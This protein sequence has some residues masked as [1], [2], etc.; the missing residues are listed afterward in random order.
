MGFSWRKKG[1]ESVYIHKEN[2]KVLV[3]GN[4]F[5]DS[6]LLD[7][8]IVFAVKAHA[9]TE[10][11]GKG[12]PYIVHPMEAVEIVAT[13][14]SDQELLAAAALHDTVEDT[15]VT[16]EDIRKEFGE[17]VAKIVEEESDKFMEGV[18][19]A[20]SWHG[21]KQAA[22][23]RLTAASRD[24]K[25]VALGDKLSNA[26]AIYRDYVQQGD[27]LWKIF[28]VTDK[29]EHEWHYRGLARALSDLAGTFAFVEF[30][31]LVQKVFGDPK[32]ECVNLRDYEVSGE[33]FTAVS[34][35]HK[36][37]S[38][39]I[40]L[41]ASFVPRTEA[42]RELE[43][44]RN[45]NDKGVVI[46]KAYRLVTDGERI[47]VEFE[48]IHPK[49]SFARAISYEPEKLEFYAREFAREAKKL[50]STPCDVSLFRPTEL[51]LKEA[52]LK[53]KD[54]DDSMKTK[55]L[56]FVDSVPL[57]KTCIHGD[58]HIGNIITNGEKN[59]WIDLSAFAYGNPLFDVGMLYF[60]CKL[61]SDEN[62][63]KNY[64]ISKTQMGE[65]WNAFADEYF[66]NA[67]SPECIDEKMRPF[68][69]LLMILYS[70]WGVPPEG[71]VEFV[72]E[73]FR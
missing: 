49:K 27:E 30:E 62:V 46:P 40:K 65:V 41:Y 23:D 2:G 58:L 53:S 55:I 22:I 42:L 60:V 20:D 3:M 50:H 45:L 48:R 64:H 6:T 18:S 17:R 67:E 33:G 15:D 31:S 66:G 52:V 14:T 32:P 61:C 34:Y 21:R 29:A 59:Y 38:T 68:A 5:L 24:A 16:F 71:L 72:C 9:N 13:M 39:M 35:N 57:S 1:F 44:A 12:F 37:G 11:R 56:K 26:R 47:G 73:T 70:T 19:E 4:K 28:H 7:R 63:R 25:M 69:A 51:R 36:D 8:A 43:V 54:F 10:R